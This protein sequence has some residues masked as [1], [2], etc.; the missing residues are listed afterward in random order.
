MLVRAK[1]ETNTIPKLPKLTEL[2][3]CN[4][5]F[6]QKAWYIILFL[7]F[8]FDLNN[9]KDCFMNNLFS[10]DS[11]DV[12]YIFL[13]KLETIFIFSKFKILNK[14]SESMKMILKTRITVLTGYGQSTWLTVIKPGHIS[15]YSHCIIKKIFC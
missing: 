1:Y 14:E 12:I 15:K 10:F 5:H 8:S 4:N 9:K 13:C 6:Y 2:F 11:K 3:L 7:W